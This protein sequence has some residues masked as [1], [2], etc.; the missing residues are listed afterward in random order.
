MA[1]A[2]SSCFYRL[3][4]EEGAEGGR[5]WEGPGRGHCSIALLTIRLLIDKL[6]CYYYYYYYYDY[7]YY[8]Y[9]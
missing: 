2:S 5:Q 7:Y 8:Y 4:E 6:Y 3:E 9:Y 1:E